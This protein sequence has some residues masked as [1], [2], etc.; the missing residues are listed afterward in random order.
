MEGKRLCVVFQRGWVW[1]GV[2]RRNR[3][4]C[5]WIWR[6]LQ[7]KGHTSQLSARRKK[8]CFG[9]RA[10]PCLGQPS[11]G[12]E[13]GR[14]L[15]LSLE[16]SLMPR[17]RAKRNS[18]WAPELSRTDWLRSLALYHIP[19][20]PG[21]PTNQPTFGH[22]PPFWASPTLADGQPQDETATRRDSLVSIVQTANILTSPIPQPPPLSPHLGSVE[23]EVDQAL[24]RHSQKIAVV[25]VPAAWTWPWPSKVGR[26][27]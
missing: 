15:E 27:P 24:H 19:I 16:G 25:T 13:A 14:P 10:L 18:D 23:V 9:C 11:S 3:L 8:N 22:R 5:R 6:L 1:V 17:H 7:S 4:V 21:Q 2:Q 26:E 12:C 20:L